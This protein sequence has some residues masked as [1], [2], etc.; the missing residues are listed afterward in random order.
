[1]SGRAEIDQLLERGRAS[2]LGG[3]EDGARAS[4]AQGFELAREARDAE[5]MGEAALSLAAGYIS[6]THFGRVPAYLFEAHNLAAGVTRTRLAVALVRA[7]VYSGE[8]ARAVPFAAEAIEGAEAFGDP[9]LLAEALD[10]QLLTNWGP[11]DLNERLRITSRLEDT[12]AHL[13]DPE[14]RMSAH[15]W[16]MTTAMEM[17]D[18]PTMRR[19]LRALQNLADETGSTRIRFFSEARNGMHA[20]VVGDLD[21]AR[22]HREAAMAAGTAAGEPDVIPI[23]HLL[24]AS[25]AVQSGDH[26]AVAAEAGAYERESRALALDTV[27]AEAVALWVAAGDLDRARSQLRQIAG[28]GLGSRPRDADWLL[29]ITCLT[30]AAAATG[31]LDM[32]EEGYALLEPYAGRGIANGGAAGFNGVVDGYLSAA[33]LALGRDADARRWA[34]SAAELAEHVGAAWWMQRYRRGGAPATVPS[35][36]RAV[37]LPGADDIWTIGREG[38]TQAVREMKGFV[39]LRHIVRQP[40]VEISALDLSNW[41]AGHAGSG[42][43]QPSTGDLIDRQAFAAYRRRLT[44]IDAELDELRQWGDISRIERM[45]EERDALLAEIRAATGLGARARQAGGT[46]ERARIAVRKAVA[47]AIDRI[48]EVDAGLERMLRDC[49]HTGARCVYI[50]DPARPVTWLTDQ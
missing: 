12:V 23:E 32:T 40:G 1:M 46:S 28:S 47:A 18:M 15:L 42:V 19:Q 8:P 27:A 25:I 4:F 30:D 39:Y 38:A 50:P 7:W 10:A 31:D 3:D 34:D 21:A 22:R 43:D 41:A 33:A 11:D 16:R 24:G 49:V 44:D 9:T 48:A 5:A 20:L 26:A 36:T 2:R 37:L 45:A 35:Q 6:G 17:L 14:A 29:A 13:A